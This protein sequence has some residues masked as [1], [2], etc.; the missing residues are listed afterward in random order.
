MKFPWMPKGRGDYWPLLPA[1]FRRDGKILPVNPALLV[2]TGADGTV[3]NIGLAAHLGSGRVTS[4]K[5]AQRWSEDIRSF[6]C[7]AAP[8]LARSRSKSADLGSSCPVSDSERRLFRYLV[9]I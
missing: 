1:G 7:R 6:T 4:L 2:D 5:K 3:L 8:I 9:G